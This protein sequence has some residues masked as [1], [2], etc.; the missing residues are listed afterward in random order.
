VTPPSSSSSATA[1]SSSAEFSVAGGASFSNDLSMDA[2]Q[3]L[4]PKVRKIRRKKKGQ[5]F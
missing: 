1:S 3:L 5:K 4:P 2:S